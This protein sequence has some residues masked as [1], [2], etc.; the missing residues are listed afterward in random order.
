MKRFLRLAVS[1]MVLTAVMASTVFGAGWTMGQGANS[2]RWWY[3]LG[4]GAYYGSPSQT[5][6]WQWLDGNGDGMAECYAFDQEGWMY[7]DTVT[8]DGYQVNADGAWIVDGA[9]QTMAVT[10]GY[11]GTRAQ[12][13]ESQENGTRILIAYFSKTGTTEAAAREIQRETGGDLFEITAAE[14]YPSSYES[15]VNRALRERDE[16]ARPPLS[17]AVENMSEYDVILLGY[18]IWWHTAPMVIDTFIESYDL[19]GKTILPFATSGGSDVEESMPDVRRLGEQQGASV[20]TGLTANAL[21]SDTI[22]QWL[23][24]NG[25]S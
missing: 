17:S 8:P 20:G 4:N 18:P 12:Q 6:E 16:N 15:T 21:D 3:D 11:G 23:E 25:I 13:P 14:P 9:V 22:R 2:A 1:V 7:A 24:A 19:S 5:V 10:A